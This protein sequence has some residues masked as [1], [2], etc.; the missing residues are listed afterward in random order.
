MGIPDCYDPVFQAERRQM[1]LDKLQD[2]LP[3]CTICRKPIF[4]GKKFHTARYKIVCHGCVE[5]LMEN[6]E[7]TGY[8]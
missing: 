3:H 5:E 4:P 8:E 6:V 2:S 1:V 7:T